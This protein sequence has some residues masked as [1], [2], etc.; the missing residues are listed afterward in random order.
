[1]QD[2]NHAFKIK[3]WH[4]AICVI[5]LAVL[6]VFIILG[7]S[8]ST[9]EINYEPVSFKNLNIQKS[10][11]WAIKNSQE[12]PPFSASCAWFVSQ[13][14]W[15]GGA[16]Q[17]FTWNGGSFKGQT[18]EVAS[19]PG[20]VASWNAQAFKQMLIDSG[21]QSES[22]NL[23]ENY[24]AKAKLADIMAYDW[25]GDGTTDHVAI[26]TNISEQD[27]PEVSEWSLSGG[28]Q[29]TVYQKRSWNWSQI[30]NLPLNKVD[31]MKNVKIE[32]IRLNNE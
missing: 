24:V 4:I 30:N 15:H 13:A 6:A 3:A 5:G 19:R 11:S 23:S 21:Y 31:Y 26:V 14:L 27:Y 32:L 8:A 2:K 25:E 1:M 17:T 20:A 9:A 10:A 7:R 28:D 18:F 22:L 12:T 29:A 16:P